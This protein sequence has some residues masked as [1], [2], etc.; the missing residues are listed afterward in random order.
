[1]S[2]SGAARNFSVKELLSAAVARQEELYREANPKSSAHFEKACRWLPAGSTRATVFY[3]PFP[4]TIK[5]GEGAYIEDLDGHRYRNFVGEFT[6]GLY[7]HDTVLLNKILTE[8]SKTGMM[9]SGPSEYEAKLAEIICTRF[10]SCEKVRFCNSGTEANLLALGLARNA[11]KREA[12]LVFKGAY[13]GG[14]LTF[15][16]PDGALNVPLRTVKAVYNDLEGTRELI[17]KNKDILGAAIIEPMMGAGGCIP[18]DRAFLQML[19]EETAKNDIVL[20]FDEVMTSRLSP[21]GLQGVH[22]IKP[23]LTSFGKYMGGG[24]SFGAVGGADKIM[25]LLDARIDGAVPHPGTFNNNIASMIGGYFALSQHYTPEQNIALN[26]MGDRFRA[27]LNFLAREHDADLQFSGLGAV[28]SAQFVRKQITNPADAEN[29]NA[30]LLRKL[31][32]LSLLSKG[33]YIAHRCLVTLNL[34]MTEADLDAFCD[35]Y[36]EFLKENRELLSAD[37]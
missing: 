14:F 9:L 12:V 10:T 26:E 11:S 19:R 35:S 31:L 1:M 22:G 15:G 37:V 32:H 3:A 36:T 18:A 23:D 6:A 25:S 7:G 24:F 5:K 27:R 34:M 2:S 17:R 20:I 21:S 33:V 8:L 30:A 4:L 13:H 28:M 16:D 29:P